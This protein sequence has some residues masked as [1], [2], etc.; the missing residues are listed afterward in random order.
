MSESPFAAEGLQ[1]ESANAHQRCG[2][3][4]RAEEN[5]DRQARFSQYPRMHHTTSSI[6]NADGE[7]Q[8]GSSQSVTLTC[9][10]VGAAA[11]DPRDRML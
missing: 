9:V 11:R 1:G 8:V 7:L 4:P 2:Q 5:G 10:A 6:H 3:R